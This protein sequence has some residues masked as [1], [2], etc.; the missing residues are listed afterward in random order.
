MIWYSPLR[1]PS[2][3]LGISWISDEMVMPGYRFDNA[4]TAV[5][6]GAGTQLPREMV[7][8]R[9]SA[10]CTC[11]AISCTLSSMRRA[12]STASCPLWFSRILF[13][14]RSNRETCS[15]SSSFCMER[16]KAGW[17]MCSASAAWESVPYLWKAA[18]CCSCVISTMSISLPPPL[19][20]SINPYRIQVAYIM[21]LS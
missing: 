19:T 17:E 1:S 5:Q 15:S 3:S 2:S 14:W 21:G 7:R 12:W 20:G 11:S 18:R 9:R 8:L 16:L 4:G 6:V 10:A 13:F